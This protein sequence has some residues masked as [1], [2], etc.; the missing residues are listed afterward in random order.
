MVALSLMISP[1]LDAAPQEQQVR[2]FGVRREK[3]GEES[4][5]PAKV[6]RVQMSEL[7]IESFI[8]PHIILLRVT[9]TS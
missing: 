7:S 1:Y 5:Y 3:N 9:Q 4:E 2:S 8:T 6:E